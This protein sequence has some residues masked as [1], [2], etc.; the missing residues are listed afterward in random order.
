MKH[1]QPKLPVL[2][3]CFLALCAVLNMAGANLALLLRIPLYLDTLGTFLS[4]LLLG[5]AWGM[6]PGLISGMLTGMTTDVYSFFYLPVQLVTGCV[7]GYLLHDKSF[8]SEKFRLPLYALGITLPGTIV[9]ASITSFLFGGITSSG[10]AVLVQ[11]LHKL[12]LGLTASVFCVQLVTDYLD[13]A[14]MLAAAIV[15]LGVFPSS[16]WSVIKKGQKEHGQI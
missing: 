4:A 10:S 5:P 6:V 9:S 8:R 2:Q 12:G 7:A 3:M 1:T 16:I 11:V 14:V 13:R 15:V